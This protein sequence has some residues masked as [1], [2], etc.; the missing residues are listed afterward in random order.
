MIYRVCLAMILLLFGGCG[1]LKA[2]PTTD[3]EINWRGNCEEQ[4]FNG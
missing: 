4:L 3:C 2:H 1:L